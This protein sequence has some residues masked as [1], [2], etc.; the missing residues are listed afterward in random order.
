MAIA[1]DHIR[2]LGLQDARH[3]PGRFG[4]K[5]AGRVRGRFD[6]FRP[7]A[8]SLGKQDM[9]GVDRDRLRRAG[10]SVAVAGPGK[11][12]NRSPLAGSCPDTVDS[13]TIRICRRPASVE[14][15]RRISDRSAV[16]SSLR[17]RFPG[18]RAGFGTKATR[19]FALPAGPPP[20]TITIIDHDERRSRASPLH[21]TSSSEADNP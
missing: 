8:I 12:P 6:A 18:Q 4:G 13:L 19:F 21:Q 20:G 9:I 2:E 10:I 3:L 17:F 16:P 14:L 11:A 15:R 1:D 5:S 7:A